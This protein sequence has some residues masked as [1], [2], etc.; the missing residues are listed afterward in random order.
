M[1]KPNTNSNTTATTELDEIETLWAETTG[2]AGVRIA[3]LDGPVDTSHPCFTGARLTRQET[4][5][6]GEPDQGFAT[7]H[8]THIASVIFGAHNSPVRG[9]APGCSGLIVPVFSG[10]KASSL[11]PCSQLDLARAITQAVQHRADIINIS[12]GELDMSGEAHPL[13]AN[14]VRLCAKNGILIVAAAG[15]DGCECLHVPA[16]LPTVLVVGAMDTQGN[17]LAFSNWGTAYQ[18]QGILAPGKGIVGAM[19]GGGTVAR[20]GTSFAT[21]IVSGIVALLMSIQLER[22]EKPNVDVIRKAILETAIGCEEKPVP[23]CSR[24]LAGRLNIKA[25]FTHLNQ[26]GRMEPSE[27]QEMESV[28]QISTKEAVIQEQ[29]NPMKN[30]PSLETPM[31][32]P[33]SKM[34]GTFAPSEASG[35]SPSECASGTCGT[36]SLVYTLGRLD[37]DLATEA[38][39]DALIQQGLTNPH[40]P[41]ALLS[42]LESAPWEAQNVTWTLVQD[43][44]PIYAIRPGGAFADQVYVRLRE[45]LGDQLTSGVERISVPGATV[46]NATLMNGQSV[47]AIFPEIRG[48]YSWSTAELVEAV[49]GKSPAKSK[50]ADLQRYQ[51]QSEDISGFLDRVY[52]ELRNLGVAPQ[53]RAINFAAT[54]AF[55]VGTVYQAA[56]QADMKLAEIGVER[57]PISRPGS[58]CWDVLLTFFNP[59]R[60]LEQANVVY[61]FTVDVS[62]IMP[63]TVGEIRSWHVY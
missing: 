22:G 1:Q 20:S 45:F 25:T 39:R 58:D 18:T 47:P 14:A 30:L 16:A 15:N 46:G 17:P 28:D 61:R 51:Q 2:N 57:S 8:G 55:Q 56:I 53:E 10:G 38:R 32:S 7:Q 54:N 5:V 52:H 12:G 34:V 9:I 6:S 43:G 59:S 62:D 23:N 21:P 31:N 11:A 3:V 4:V 40:D 26:G 37:F 60:R 49:L 13:L 44:T 36:S 63:I 48:M 27:Q 41:N 24:L 42:Y 35:I 29:A 33:K 50:R 19:P